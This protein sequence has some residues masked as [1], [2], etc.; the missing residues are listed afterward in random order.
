MKI[1]I[2]GTRGIPNN[3]GGFEQFAQYLSLGLVEKGNRVTVYNS[4]NHQW[5]KKEW[6][7]VEIVHCNDPEKKMG[8]TG[9]FIYDLNC[10]KD[11][12]KRSFDIILQLGYTS[13][14]V[15][16]WLLPR[17]N[18]VVTTNMDGLE[19]QRTKYSKKVQ[20]FL[21]YAEKLA[22]KFSD[23]LISDSLVIQNYI[24]EKYNRRSIFIP[25]GAHLFTSPNSGCLAK[26][27]VTKHNYNMLIARLEPENNIE[28]ILDG[29][30]KSNLKQ[31]FLVIGNHE[32]KYGKFLKNKF[33]NH[34]LIKFIGAIYDIAILNNLRH[35]SNLYFHGHTV[36]GTNPS[37]LE[38]MASQALIC[39]SD[40]I[41]NRSILGDDAFYFATAK[42]VSKLILNQYKDAQKHKIAA[43]EQKITD[44]YN[45]PFIIDQYLAHF[46]EILQKRHLNIN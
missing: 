40:N 13:S 25:Y 46:N 2:I 10:I 22:V 42:D 3:Y 32:T 33:K 16:G 45:W 37:L 36:G 28:T 5:K 6:N 44:T 38:A 4:N 19:W 1:A 27:D 41:F 39:A 43:N 30:A 29:I 34:D 15:W 21:K 17:K 31:P 35:F 11:V 8:L 18:T 23:H 20:F 7:G 9:Q 26:Y 14:S 12:R 24:K